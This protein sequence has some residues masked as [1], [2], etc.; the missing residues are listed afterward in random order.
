MPTVPLGSVA[1]VMVNAA[2]IVMVNDWVAV[3]LAASAAWM[4]KLNVPAAM[5]VPVR[6]PAAL[7][8]RPVGSAPEDDQVYGEVP[9]VATRVVG[10]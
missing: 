9:P 10:V 6:L 4:V 7:R 1:V 8:V 3:A 5:G 2:A